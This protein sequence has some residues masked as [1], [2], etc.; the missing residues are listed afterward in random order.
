[1]VTIPQLCMLLLPLL[2]LLPLLLT[3]VAAVA[4]GTTQLCTLVLPSSLLL[5]VAAATA[6][7]QLCSA[8]AAAEGQAAV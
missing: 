7:A 5:P 4:V 3:V 8:G 2:M 6:A 1:M